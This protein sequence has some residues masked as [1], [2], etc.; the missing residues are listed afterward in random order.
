MYLLK[1]EFL[2][3]NHILPKGMTINVLKTVWIIVMQISLIF[4]VLEMKGL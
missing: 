4:L 1:I 3:Q 2:I